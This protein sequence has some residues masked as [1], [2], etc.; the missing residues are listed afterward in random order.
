MSIHLSK[1]SLSSLSAY[2]LIIICLSIH[3]SIYPISIPIIYRHV[4]SI[5]SDHSAHPPTLSIHLSGLPSASICLSVCPSIRPS[6]H[7]VGSS[8]PPK[9]GDC[10]TSYVV[11]ESLHFIT[12]LSLTGCIFKIR[13]S[14]S[15]S[16]CCYEN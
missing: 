2:H 15:T 4:S 8:L 7:P 14:M 3:S 16:S 1:N 10:C 11:L 6:I 5:Y 9:D 12:F 13:T